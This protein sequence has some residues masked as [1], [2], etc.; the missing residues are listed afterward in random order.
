MTGPSTTPRGEHTPR[1]GATWQTHLARVERLVADDASGPRP[2]RATR[3]AAARSTEEPMTDQTRLR[4]AHQARRAKEHQ[5]DDIRRALCDIGF[6]QD[7]DPYSHADLADVIRQN[8]AALR[9]VGEA[10]G[11]DA[12]D[13]TAPAPAAT[14]AT[15]PDLPPGFGP[16]VPCI[17]PPNE[18]ATSPLRNQLAA[19]I[20]RTNLPMWH[21][22]ARYKAADA[23]LAELY[24][25]T[26]DLQ[27]R[28]TVAPHDPEAEQERDGAYR[29]R[30]HLV[31]LVA[32]GL[33][34]QV[35]VAPAPDVDEPG[36][37]ILY[38][39]LHGRQCSW[40]FSP[41]DAD[42]IEHFD[43]VPADD[44]CAQW[45]GHTTDAKY[46]HIDYLA[47]SLGTP[48]TVRGR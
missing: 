43:H 13:L 6:M 23:V 29:E 31:A 44:P 37:Q 48:G 22:A 45:D 14:E 40:H 30:A 10:D 34:E 1:P 18:P 20:G 47:R 36:W 27:H 3:R 25:P 16:V 8:G 19:A 35:V 26:A 21:K 7:D 12:H 2:N 11:A 41:R 46:E 38:A 33:A 9:E 17:A 5:L 42:L 39:T 15:E 32:G 28:F 24:G 4:L